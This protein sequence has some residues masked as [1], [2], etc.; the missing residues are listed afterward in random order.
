[1][2]DTGNRCCYQLIN[3]VND[4][5]DDVTGDATVTLVCS[6]PPC[7]THETGTTNTATVATAT[8]EVS[9]RVC[10]NPPCETHETGTTNTTTTAAAGM[11]RPPQVSS[12]QVT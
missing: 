3:P 9:E 6:N 7:E 12:R 2:G 8:M 10:S 5:T 1:M 4:V 11:N